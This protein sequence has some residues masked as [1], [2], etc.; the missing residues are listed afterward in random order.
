[1]STSDAALGPPRVLFITM[2]WNTPVHPS[3]GLGVLSEVLSRAGIANACLY[4]NLLLPRRSKPTVYGLGDADPDFYDDR[5]AGM[6][7]VPSLYPEVTVEQIA[8]HVAI[9]HIHTSSRE[10]QIELGPNWVRWEND[11]KHESRI[12]RLLIEQ[13]QEDIEHGAT[14][15]SRCMERI[16]SENFDVIGFSLTFE[17]QLVASLALAKRIKQRWPERRIVFG[18]AACASIQGI[19]TLKSFPWLDV[20]CLG[21]GEPIVVALVEALRGGGDLAAI[22]GLAYR[23]AGAVHVTAHAEQ[24]ANLDSVPIPNYDAYVEQKASSEWASTR[25]RLLFETSRGCWWGA[26]HLCTF[27]GL[28]AEA[29]VYRS[30]SPERVLEEIETFAQRWNI[31]GGLHAVDNILDTRYFSELIP[32]LIE[33]QQQRPMTFFFEIKSN[34]KLW[35]MLQLSVAGFRALQPGIESFSDHILELMDKGATAYQ[36][37]NFIKWA[38]QTSISPHYNILMRNPGETV[39][40]YQEMT[41]LIPFISHLHPPSA[42]ANMQLERFSPYFMRPAAFGI[43]NVRPKAHYQEMFP[44][45]SIDLESLVYQFDY[46]HDDVDAPELM[47][48][49]QETMRAMQA[50]QTSFTPHR[51]VYFVLGA[52][53]VVVD[54]RAGSESKHR[55][56]GLEAELFRYLDSPRTFALIEKQFPGHG[57]AELR[58]LLAGLV[59]RRFVHHDRRKDGYLAVVVRVYQTMDEFRAHYLS[60]TAA[61]QARRHGPGQSAPG[62]PAGDSPQRTPRRLPLATP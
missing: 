10:G 44:D 47:A 19:T 34:L 9:R 8:N 29:L 45:P 18:G 25:T 39:E 49:R 58:S 14:C 16:A 20:V 37:I 26:K 32:R 50:W 31:D 59:A 24:I 1:M 7:F 42:I 46:D 30:K 51:L 5:S 22:P 60:E 43:R 52:D 4:G 35:Q 11:W 55:L 56:R 6:S 13:T 2:P 57:A 62:L 12:R 53:L 27:C 17:T 28:N 36:Q 21:E 23:H 3:L 61:A 48:A 40:D 41:A 33:R 54:S 38:Q 15:L